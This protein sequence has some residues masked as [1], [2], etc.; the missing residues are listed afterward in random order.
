MSVRG[1]DGAGGL[2][3]ADRGSAGG[4]IPDRLYAPFKALCVKLAEKLDTPS[5]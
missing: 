1:N 2:V 3:I 5:Y 4:A